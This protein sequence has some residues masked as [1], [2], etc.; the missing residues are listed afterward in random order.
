MEVTG[1]RIANT[2]NLELVLSTAHD[3]FENEAVKQAKQLSLG[4][5]DARAEYQVFRIPQDADIS[6]FHSLTIWNTKYQ[7]NFATAPLR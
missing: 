3:A 2:P 7:V 4:P 1:L 5:V 6:E